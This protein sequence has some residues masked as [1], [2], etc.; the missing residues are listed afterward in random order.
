[1]ELRPTSSHRVPRCAFYPFAATVIQPFQARTIAIPAFSQQEKPSGEKVDKYLDAGQ[2]PPKGVIVHYYLREKPEGEIILSF[3]DAEGKEI[4]KFS[5][6]EKEKESVGAGE[7]AGR[8]GAS[9]SPGRATLVV[10]H[11][12]KKEPHPPKEGGANRFVWNMRYADPV[13]IEGYGESEEFLTGPLAPAGTYQVQLKVGDHVYT[14]AFEIRKDPRTKAT[15]EDL[16]AQF[17]LLL[18][19]RDKLSQTHEAVNTVRSIRQQIEEWE[20]RV[21]G[22]NPA[23]IGERNEVQER[24]TTLGKTIKKKLSAIE[25]E[26]IQVKAKDQL[27]VLDH[28]IQLSA[29]F[30]L[31]SEVVS[32]ADAAPTH[33]SQQAF[34][35]LSSR[36]DRQL[37]QLHELVD[38]HVATFNQL[39]RESDVPAIVPTTP[40]D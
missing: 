1:V 2:N 21:I 12:E 34:E 13:K 8:E 35:D 26:L 37:Q 14:E 6:K 31:L 3:L 15:Q 11:K 29:K 36:L 40:K 39:I 23:L 18:A 17:D 25:E 30:A 22:S 24:V 4:K 38:T 33:Q 19:I 10:A 20:R 9:S 16:Q 5:S 28:P 7:A 32:S 27:D